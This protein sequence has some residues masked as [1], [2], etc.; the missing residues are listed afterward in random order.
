M[1]VIQACLPTR[2]SMR[3]KAAMHEQHS[4]LDEYV[5][6]DYVNIELSEITETKNKQRWRFTFTV[7]YNR[8]FD[9]L[10]LDFPWDNAGYVSPKGRTENKLCSVTRL[11]ETNRVSIN[12]ASCN[13]ICS[14]S[15][16]EKIHRQL[17][18]QH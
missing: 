8:K 2:F 4:W 13:S 12:R 6:I 5:G 3:V 16:G 9:S 10:L 15:R 14:C 18:E 7:T 1:Y 11:A 17:R